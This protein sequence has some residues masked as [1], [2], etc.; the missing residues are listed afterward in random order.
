MARRNLAA[1]GGGTEAPSAPA[2]LSMHRMMA[3]RGLP[4][5]KALTP[6][7]AVAENALAEI[8]ARLELKTASDQEL[9]DQLVALA[10]RV[11]RHIAEHSY[12]FSATQAYHALVKL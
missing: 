7:L 11:E 3:L 4:V 10:A 6:E 12:R 1:A 5:A 9:L 2:H 8:T